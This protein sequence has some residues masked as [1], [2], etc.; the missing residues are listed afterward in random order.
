MHSIYLPFI[1]YYEC[2]SIFK[3]KYFVSAFVTQFLKIK[4]KLHFILIYWFF[5]IVFGWMPKI[6]YEILFEC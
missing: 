6:I 1:K 4:T 5:A 2:V 3:Q